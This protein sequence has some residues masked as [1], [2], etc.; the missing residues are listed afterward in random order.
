MTRSGPLAELFRWD[1][2]AVPQP[3][4]HL[5]GSA[6]SALTLWSPA[7]LRVSIG[8]SLKFLMCSQECVFG[9]TQ[10]SLSG[11]Q[12][13][14]SEQFCGQVRRSRTSVGGNRGKGASWLGFRFCSVKPTSNDLQLTA[15]GKVTKNRRSQPD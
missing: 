7:C 6:D 1:A 5:S 10:I 3:G 14:E 15:T 11:T 12:M 4:L 8:S 13:R 2:S 9:A